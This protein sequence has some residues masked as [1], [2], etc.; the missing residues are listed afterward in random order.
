[1][2]QDANPLGQHPSTVSNAP[3]GPPHPHRHALVIGAGLAGAAVVS[4]LARR[5]WL[6]E[7]IDASSGPAEAA[8]GLPLGMLSPHHTRSPTP[9]SELSA[10]GVAATRAEL[11]RCLAP[12]TGWQA[13]EVDNHLHDPGRWPAVLVRPGALVRAW[14]DEA[15]ALGRLRCHW[16]AP[17]AQLQAPGAPTPAPGPT[18]GPRGEARNQNIA[19]GPTQSKA[20][21]E[22]NADANADNSQAKQL[23]QN[24]PDE[25]S[26][27]SPLPGGDWLA[28][29]AQGR[30]LARA[31]VVVVCAA[32][33][34]LDLLGDTGLPLRPVR[35]QL[36]FAALEGPAL[37]E[38]PQRQSGVFVPAYS[39]NGL[40]PRWPNRIWSVGA[41]YSRG[42]SGKELRA[43]DHQENA[44]RLHSICPP[45]A[46]RMGTQQAN[47]QL[48]GWA[49][50]RCASLDRLPL[51]GA[52]PDLVAMAIA[53][54]AAGHRRGRLGLGDVPRQ[55]GLYTLCAL[56][57]RGITLALSSAHNLADQIE[58]RPCDLHPALPHA[59]QQAL[60]PARFVWRSARRQGTATPTK[61][62]MGAQGDG[63]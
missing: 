26:G 56:G 48:L 30:C 41:T 39:D 31:P 17:V 42:D 8:S 36:S 15:T 1:M 22:H 46:E 53:W 59:L 2:S 16:N 13:C 29:D 43:R 28:L 49:Q 34:S 4:A 27:P 58:G 20:Q 54:R 62:P 12:G 10:I 18:L 44:D 35:G 9:L 50:V 60:D 3:L 38:R 7:L 51:V 47:G 63:P 37:A 21:S 32:L 45:A 57:S 40:A 5:G 24:K 23:R 25:P 19:V 14:L 55:A 61:A 33:G 11:L 52:L 6:V